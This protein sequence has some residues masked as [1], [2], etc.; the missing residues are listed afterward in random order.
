M[1]K[2]GVTVA[3]EIELEDPIENM[4]AQ[5]VKEVATKTSDVAG[6]GTTTA[7]VL[8]EAIFREGLK[9]I[10]AGA[11]SM[12][13][14]RGIQKATEAVVDEMTAKRR[15]R[16]PGLYVGTGK[17]EEIAARADL[18]QADVILFDNDLSPA[19]TRNLEKALK[20][21]VIDRD[22]VPL[23]KSDDPRAVGWGYWYGKTLATGCV[24]QSVHLWSPQGRLTRWLEELGNHVTSLSFTADSRELFF[25]LGGPAA[26]DGGFI[27]NL[28]TNRSVYKCIG[29]TT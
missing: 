29:M 20:V 11:D 26:T 12:A 5:M 13:L 22:W 21:K 9:M 14:S 16:H 3:K 1:T 28:A 10:A 27:V 18:N 24:D 19:Q 8:A 15:K 4:G 7:T 25:T 23:G 17:A 2:D 6:D